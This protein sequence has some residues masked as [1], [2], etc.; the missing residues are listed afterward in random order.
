MP[1]SGLC[2]EEREALLFARDQEITDPWYVPTLSTYDQKP[3]RIA[4]HL[5]LFAERKRSIHR[6]T[7]SLVCL[8][9]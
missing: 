1:L 8:R 3:D 9:S 5:T 6:Q 4:D 7:I 2:Y